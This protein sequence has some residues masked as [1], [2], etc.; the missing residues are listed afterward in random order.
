MPPLPTAF[1]QRLD[2]A[3][4]AEIATNPP[5]AQHHLAHRRRRHFQ[6]LAAAAAA[7]VMVG[8]GATLAKTVLHTSVRPDTL[9][10]KVPD[11]SPPHSQQ[12]EPSRA[13]APRNSVA[14]EGGTD[15]RD[16]TLATQIRA[17]LRTVHPAATAGQSSGCVASLAKG[18]TPLLVDVARYD[19]APATIVV[20][21]GAGGGYDVWIA[22]AQ[23][24][25]LKH[26]AVSAG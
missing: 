14:G 23:C 7:V 20:L 18:A 25:I 6:L 17:A 12:D 9:S 24:A 5:G 8:A 11:D 1:A 26:T 3:I 13:V 22:G 2:A 21:K 16:A 15:Y 19:G 10:G 4:A